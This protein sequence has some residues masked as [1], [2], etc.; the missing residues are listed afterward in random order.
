MGRFADNVF[1]VASHPDLIIFDT[2]GDRYM[3]LPE[4]LGSGEHCDVDF[5]LDGVT[6]RPDA[7]I[8]LVE[9]GLFHPDTI[10]E[11]IEPLS[12]P[13]IQRDANTVRDI[14][15]TMADAVRL[16][17]AVIVAGWKLRRGRSCRRF[18]H[19]RS[20]A[21]TG[22]SPEFDIALARLQAM[23]LVLPTP[24]RCLPACIVTATFLRMLG[25]HVE[26]IFGVRSHPFAAHCWIEIGGVVLDDDLDRVR[27]YRPIAVGTI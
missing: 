13:N 4:S 26:I 19:A 9:A 15:R 11:P 22:L 17:V 3:A 2:A 7:A 20:T 23:R 27:A 14:G 1:V 6:L 12:R 21:C 25:H 24:R 5:G 18:F 8:P 10:A 16:A